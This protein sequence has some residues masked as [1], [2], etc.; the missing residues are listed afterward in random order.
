M[1]VSETMVTPLVWRLWKRCS[2]DLG[3]G[4]SQGQ[5]GGHKGQQGGY[6]GLQGG[7]QGVTWGSP[8]CLDEGCGGVRLYHRR[9]EGRGGGSWFGFW[10]YALYFLTY[11]I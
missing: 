1:S 4:G 5:H 7:P 2:S 8:D 10:A 11:C 6:K 9:P 3:A